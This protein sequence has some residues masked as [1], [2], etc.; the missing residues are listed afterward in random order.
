MN[1]VRR[2]RESSS[3]SPLWVRLLLLVREHLVSRHVRGIPGDM[4]AVRLDPIRHVVVLASP[5]PEHVAEPVHQAELL[6][7]HRRHAAK[8]IGVR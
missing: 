5:A 8:Q 2:D 3:S 6:P 4:E 1:Q 7:R